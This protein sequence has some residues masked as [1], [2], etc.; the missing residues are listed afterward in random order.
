[1]LWKL[2]HSCR[3][4]SCILGA[5]AFKGRGERKRKRGRKGAEAKVRGEEGKEE[6]MALWQAKDK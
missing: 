3:F 6:G 2:Q 1:L 4:S 5:Y